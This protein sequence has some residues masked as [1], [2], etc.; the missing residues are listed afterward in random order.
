MVSCTVHKH[1]RSARGDARAVD[2]LVLEVADRKFRGSGPA[3]LECDRRRGARGHVRLQRQS[4]TRL[5]SERKEAMADESEAQEERRPSK[6]RLKRR[7]WRK[8]GPTQKVEI[9]A[10]GPKG[11]AAAAS[12]KKAERE[13]R[14]GTD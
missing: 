9:Q 12:Q 8:N 14:K 11:A 13:K 6:P 3:F 4:T 2:P 1:R 7:R 5:P 10:L